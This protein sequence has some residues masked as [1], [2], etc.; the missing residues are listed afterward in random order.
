MDRR[1]SLASEVTDAKNVGI[2]KSLALA[3]ALL[4]SACSAVAAN[5][6][7]PPSAHSVAT[8]FDDLFRSSSTIGRFELLS[9]TEAQSRHLKMRI[10]TKNKNKTLIIIDEPAKDSGTAT[11]KVDQNLWN[12]L[13]KISRTIRVPPSM[14]ISSWIG[15][16]FTNDDLVK[17]SSYEH[18]FEAR[19]GDH[20]PVQD[21]WL[22]VL[23]V[24]PGK[25]GQPNNNL[26]EH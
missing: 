22:Y 4:L 24:K 6:V 19:L 20:T 18:D 9:K 21:G 13:P 25:S 15:T 26:S 1:E 11:L 5:E 23:T 10:W 17:D 2:M 8:M 3:L 16:D 7:K 14:M 12:Y